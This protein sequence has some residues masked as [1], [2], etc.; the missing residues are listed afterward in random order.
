[1]VR[2]NLAEHEFVVGQFNYRFKLYPAAVQ[3]FRT[4]IDE[5]PDTEG[6][7]RALFHL[8]LALLKMTMWGETK[9]TFD[10][11]RS[12]YP[13]SPYVQKVPEQR[14]P[15]AAAEAEAEA[16]AEDEDEPEEPAEEEAA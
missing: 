2:Q 1:V 13:D 4:V 7:D 12:E 16:E 6:Q 3:R 15:P 11:L 14:P 10:R 5:Y 9:E 8:G